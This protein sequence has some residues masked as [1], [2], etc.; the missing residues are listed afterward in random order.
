LDKLLEEG[1][2]ISNMEKRKAV[3]QKI[4][5]ILHEDLPFAPIFAY[6]FMYGKKSGLEGYKINPYVTDITWNIQEW[7][8]S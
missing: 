6:T 3:Y 1:V 5:A 2:L 8:W 7:A 4:Q